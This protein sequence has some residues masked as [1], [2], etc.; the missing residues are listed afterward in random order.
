NGLRVGDILN[1][2][3]KALYAKIKEK[4]LHLLKQ[5]DFVFDIT[6]AEKEWFSAIE[7]LRSFQLT[8]SEYFLNN[9][10]ANGQKILAEGAQGTMLD[11][12]FG[13]YPFVT[14]SNTI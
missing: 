7:F 9:A 11:I 2:D 3:F 1:P 14:S 13:T 10:L 8:D 4:H 6:D 5:Y 12:D